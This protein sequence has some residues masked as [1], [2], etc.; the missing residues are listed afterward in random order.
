MAK[1]FNK[2]LKRAIDSHSVISFDV[3][4]TLIK[5]NCLEP[6]DI[7][8]IVENEYNKIHEEKIADFQT[9]RIK[10]EEKARLVHSNSQDVTL[11]QIYE[12]LEL[13]EEI[14][15]QLKNIEVK[16][17]LAFCVINKNIKEAY[18]YCVKTG[19]TVICVSD[20]YLEESVIKQIL[21]N[22]GYN[23]IDKLYVSS[24]LNKTKYTGSLYDYVIKD[25]NIK[26]NDLLH[27]GDSKRA[28]YLMP[29]LKMISSYKI[30]RTV[31]NC[32]YIKPGVNDSIDANILYSF[33]NNSVDGSEDDYYRLGYE[34]L[35]P[36]VVAF[37][38]WLYENVKCQPNCKLFF[39]ARDMQFTQKVFNQLY[40]DQIANEYLYIS[41]TSVG[42]PMLYKNNTF[43]YFMSTLTPKN[44]LISEMLE[45]KG[46]NISNLDKLLEKYGINPKQEYNNSTLKNEAFKRF[47][48]EYVSKY[49]EENF[50]GEYDNFLKYMD[51]IGFVPGE[52]VVVDLGWNGT[53]QYCLQRIYNKSVKGYYLGVET[54]LYNNMQDSM[55]GYLFDGNRNQEISKKVYSFKS[56]FEVFFSAT[57]GTTL[58]YSDDQ[59]N[60][61][62]LGEYENLNSNI[63]DTIQKGT[64][65][66]ADGFKLY[67]KLCDKID[68]QSILEGLIEL[69]TRPN[70]EQA[71]DF[72]ELNF[73]NLTKGKFAAPRK[74]R[75][76]LF[77]PKMLK[78]DMFASEWK[79]GFM[80]RLL[81]IK[82]P[83]YSIYSY[84]K[85]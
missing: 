49:I 22:A 36:L 75:F 15:F 43:D 40:K 73:D 4:D 72:G 28:D 23:D 65:D 55:S 19:K 61:V 25:L 78:K 35:G 81:K 80:K 67:E 60:P 47:Y 2:K 5:R 37:C 63:I 3:F 82:L 6:K 8:L 70:Y 32:K 13:D 27:I 7:F 41:R 20:M 59:T 56:L 84:L 24:E 46:I 68:I 79:I 48:N 33:I 38:K 69:G 74:L 44:L 76:Y 30:K 64:K 42:K 77:H 31:N 57:H 14:S 11:E 10:A 66:F 18:E 53:I 45:N 51:S 83:Y 16:T 9:K 34:L 62:I 50:K 21:F 85:R 26:K 39:C 71:C 17:E 52:A 54:G 58:G 12:Q 29:K 1:I